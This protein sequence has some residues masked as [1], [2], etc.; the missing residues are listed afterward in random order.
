MALLALVSASVLPACAVSL[1]GGIGALIVAIIMAVL[2]FRPPCA[3]D[4]EASA[5]DGQIV[6]DHR[7]PDLPRP[8]ASEDRGADRKKG[9][10]KTTPCLSPP[11][12]CLSTAACLCT[13]E[14]FQPVGAPESPGDPDPLAQGELA[15]ERQRAIQKLGLRLPRDLRRRL[16]G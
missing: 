5:S 12:P 16:P 10:I 3:R 1:P 13:C 11:H 14:L 9:D 8:D 7:G 4:A 2:I 6:T 15:R